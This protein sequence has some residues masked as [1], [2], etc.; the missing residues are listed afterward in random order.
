MNPP[1]IHKQVS[2]SGLEYRRGEQ[3]VCRMGRQ[4]RRPELSA[5]PLNVV[6]ALLHLLFLLLFNS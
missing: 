3:G 2:S 5:Q 6:F 4:I 1:R